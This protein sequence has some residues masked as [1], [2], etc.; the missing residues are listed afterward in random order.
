MGNKYITDLDLL[1][2]QNWAPQ[3]HLRAGF[4]ILQEKNTFK[5]TRTT[6]SR[7]PQSA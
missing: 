7:V 2:S 1:N 4:T 6:A 5:G 3:W